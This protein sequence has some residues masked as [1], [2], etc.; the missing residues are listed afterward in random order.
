MGKGQEKARHL[1]TATALS[2]VTWH[3]PV[4][5]LP[6]EAFSMIRMKLTDQTQSL[7][8]YGGKH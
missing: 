4:L 2:A 3:H 8:L 1:L 7:D 6:N 5:S